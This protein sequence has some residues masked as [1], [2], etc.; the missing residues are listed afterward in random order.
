MDAMRAAQY[1][2]G[3]LRQAQIAHL[4]GF[5]QARHRSNR[6]FD[7]CAGRH[8]VQDIQVDVIGTQPLQARITGYGH[9]LRAAIDFQTF[10]VMRVGHETELGGDE[11]TLATPGQRLA[12][13]AFVAAAAIDVSAVEQVDAVLQRMVNDADRLGIIAGAIELA[14]AHAA[15]P[16]GRY[17]WAARAQSSLLHGPSPSL[18]GLP[19]AVPTYTG[20]AAVDDGTRPCQQQDHQAAASF[21]SL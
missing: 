10:C 12:E 19:F 5:H 3:W 6:V 14:H 15:Q 13:Q 4:A 9:V 8:A 21:C 2:D 1:V 20:Y 18:T 7:A 16:D 11:G 17:L